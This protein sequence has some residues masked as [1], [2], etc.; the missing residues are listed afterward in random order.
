[1]N[2]YTLIF[3]FSRKMYL[4]II[5]SLLKYK[6]FVMFVLFCGYVSV[7]FRYFKYAMRMAQEEAKRDLILTIK[8][9]R[10][11]KWR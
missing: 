3:D 6:I 7:F 11:D 4:K 9:I 5:N 10:K 1:M 2:L 8:T